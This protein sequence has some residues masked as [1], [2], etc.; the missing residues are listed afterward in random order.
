MLR[1]GM[2]WQSAKGDTV[3]E[4]IGKAIEYYRE[5][6]GCDPDEVEI[7]A[8]DCGKEVQSKEV[9]VTSS[10]YVLRGCLLI[11]VGEKT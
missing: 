7:N 11:G 5:K 9:S 4:S 10:R 3:S 8:A 1:R 6:Y 2:L